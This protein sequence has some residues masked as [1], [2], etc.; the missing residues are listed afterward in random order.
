MLVRRERRRL[1]FA[2]F[3]EQYLHASF[4]FLELLAA[5]AGQGNAPLEEFEGALERQIAAL[6]FLYHL[7]ELVDA[8]L[9]GRQRSFGLRLVRHCSILA[10]VAGGRVASGDGRDAGFEGDGQEPPGGHAEAPGDL[11]HE[12][13]GF[14]EGLDVSGGIA[15][16][17]DG[18]GVGLGV[19][20]A[21]GTQ[22]QRLANGS[23]LGKQ[24]A[25]SHVS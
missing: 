16:G 21:R 8:G 9:E 7:V 11:L 14:H 13:V 5:G 19:Q 22:N 3:L 12:A 18:L 2:L 23:A 20:A 15:G 17:L 10:G 1:D 24:C 6:Q 4:R 25:T